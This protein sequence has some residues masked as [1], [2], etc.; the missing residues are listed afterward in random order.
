MMPRVTPKGGSGYTPGSIRPLSGASLRDRAGRS[1]TEAPAGLRHSATIP[2][3]G[4][5]S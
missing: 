3:A 1:S 5:V 4:G 2:S